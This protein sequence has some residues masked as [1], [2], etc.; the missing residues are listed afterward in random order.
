MLILTSCTFTAASFTNETYKDEKD[1]NDKPVYQAKGSI[2]LVNG[3]ERSKP[4]SIPSTIIV[5]IDN[6]K[7]Y[8]YKITEI[9]KVNTENLTD[10]DK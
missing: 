5:K 3:T 4:Y 9:E 6:R 7:Q 10:D 1:E 8:T 2:K